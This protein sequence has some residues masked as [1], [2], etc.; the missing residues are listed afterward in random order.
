MA[1]CI[2]VTGPSHFNI[3]GHLLFTSVV[4]AKY[5][6]NITVDITLNDINNCEFVKYYSNFVFKST[7]SGV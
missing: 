3:Y 5:I 7:P 4:Y 6:R 2:E 1:L